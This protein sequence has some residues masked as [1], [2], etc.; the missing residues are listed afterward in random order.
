MDT[1]A[2]EYTAFISY[3]HKTFDTAVAKKIQRQIENYRI[4][5]HIAKRFGG[6][7]VGKVFRDRDELP[8]LADLGEGIRFALEKSEWL[9][10]ICTPELPLSK[11]CM[12]EVDYFISLGKRDKILAVLADGE[13]EDSFPP[14]L[15]FVETDGE[16]AEKEPLAA[17]VRAKTIGKSLRKVNT[18]KLRLLASILGVGFDELR[19]RQRER[20]MRMAVTASMSAAILLG[21]FLTY[22]VNQNILL[23]EQRNIARENEAEAVRQANIALENQLLAEQNWEIAEEQKL[24]AEKNAA[25]ALHQAGIAYEN[26]LLAEANEAEA[27]RQEQIARK[28]GERAVIGEAEALKQKE[29]AE[30]NEARAIAGETEAVKQAGIARENQLLAEANAEEALRQE[31]IARD[32]E[33]RAIIGEAEAL[34]QKGI[35]EANEAQ[36]IKERNNA[37]IGQ[38]KFLAGASAEQ[39]AVG[40]V[41]LAL[42]LALEAL[43]KDLDNPERP[44][45]DEAVSALHSA[46]LPKTEGEYIL[47]GAVRFDY[48]MFF[49][50]LEKEDLLLVEGMDSI[51][52][53]NSE[54]GICVFSTERI[55]G[56]TAVVKGYSYCAESSRLAVLTGRDKDMVFRIIELDNYSSYNIPAHG[57]S[58]NGF[59]FTP[60]GRYIIAKACLQSNSDF[61]AVYDVASGK[62]LFYAEPQSFYSGANGFSSVA[63]SPN[64]QYL[65]CGLY[66]T[67]GG[68]G[69]PSI[70][71]FD[72]ETYKIVKELGNDGFAYEV[73]WRPDGKQIC[74]RRRPD[75]AIE[76]W[77]VEN[78]ELTFISA[79]EGM[80]RTYTEVRYS[81]NGRYIAARTFEDA[82]F[83]YDAQEG[84]VKPFSESER[85]TFISFTDSHT[86]VYRVG[87]NSPILRFYDLEDEDNSGSL[88]SVMRLPEL[89]SNYL[90]LKDRNYYLPPA[91][92][93]ENVVVTYTDSGLYLV[94]KKVGFALGDDAAKSAATFIQFDRNDMD[95]VKAYSPDGKKFA[96]ASVDATLNVANLKMIE[97]KSAIKLQIKIYDAQTADILCV[98]QKPDK[99]KA[100]QRI[101]W[102][103]DAS[104]ILAIFGNGDVEQ[105]DTVSGALVGMIKS[106]YGTSSS[107]VSLWVSPKWDRLVLNNRAYTEGMYDMKTME[108]LY[109]FQPLDPTLEKWNYLLGLS[110][111]A[112]FSPDGSKFIIGRYKE[113]ITVDSVTGAELSRKTSDDNFDNMAISPDGNMIAYLT[114]NMIVM[115][116]SET[117]KEQWRVSTG[118]FPPTSIVWSPDSR[119]VAISKKE[120]DL[121]IVWN[122]ETGESVGEFP[123]YEPFFNR[124]GS[125]II[126]TYTP[127]KFIFSDGFISGVWPSRVI[128]LES[129]KIFLELTESGIFSPINDDI[130]TVSAI[131]KT[132]PLASM[133]KEARERISERIL[134]VVERKQF[135]LD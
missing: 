60:D 13:P 116:D 100:I 74:A 90:I 19:R 2:A 9:I 95:G 109:D 114:G 120:P 45:V 31:Q 39:L 131:Y 40:D 107:V 63:V 101:V 3:R 82:C 102:S 124:N 106:K 53:Y 99:G 62:R 10:V 23:E 91:A 26:Q 35:A 96:V 11:W 104:R 44:L 1:G 98:I 132:K 64:G 127:T 16:T 130:L 38:S 79:I 84:T 68:S 42:L 122:A 126:G 105:Y 48:S 27:L 92:L 69:F 112:A 5:A 30:I 128:D 108:K 28:N 80:E 61:I 119:F 67:N 97:E 73:T 129:G 94:W 46:L 65:A 4:P 58:M 37:L 59:E 89:Y 50:F 57:N 71:I 41:G 121:T 134:T 86:L 55:S 43:P 8:L 20:F 113:I 103:P 12:A 56:G 85:V 133:I 76:L 22:A 7:R 111:S 110:G 6:K 135:Y 32:N 70:A 78:S 21:G 125:K 36:A 117:L 77:D 81:P 123:I 83:I 87:T 15:R 54:S 75:Y 17:D 24:L 47:A 93:T 29:I 49:E 66:S 72:L 18:E 14:Q 34:K 118:E 51:N 88:R 25:E 115:M 33:K 52:L